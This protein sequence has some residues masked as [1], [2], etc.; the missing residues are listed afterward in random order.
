M[1]GSEVVRDCKSRG[2]EPDHTRESPSPRLPTRGTV[3]LE[4][5]DDP[6]QHGSIGEGSWATQAGDLGVQATFDHSTGAADLGLWPGFIT[7]YGWSG[8][9]TNTPG[10]LSADEKARCVQAQ[11]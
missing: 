6:A 11:I 2:R 5:G 7:R 8:Q 10:A 4:G 9:M 1:C 3:L